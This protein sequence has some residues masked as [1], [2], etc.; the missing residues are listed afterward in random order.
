[1]AARNERESRLALLSSWLVVFFQFALFLTIGVLLFVYYHDTG[2]TP[3]VPLDRAYPEFI[4]NHL[5]VG[6]AGLVMAAILAAAMSNLSAALNALSSTTIMDFFRPMRPQTSEVRLLQL[7]RWATVVWAV[8]LFAVGLAARHWGSV[9]ETA[10]S[11]ASVLYGSLLGVF[12]LGVLTKKPG[13]WAAIAGMSAGF[14]GNVAPAHAGSI[15][16][17][18]FDRF[19]HNVCGR[20][21]RQS[22]STQS[23]LKTSSL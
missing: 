8:V 10:L 3:P 23:T 20:L 2:Q 6:F 9:L 19:P 14:L 22:C 1:M 21:R 12:L 15:Y 11:I 7:A 16:V 13:E 5:P 4:W 18:R 17:V